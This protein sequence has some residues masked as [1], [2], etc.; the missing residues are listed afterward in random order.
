MPLQQ[1]CTLSYNRAMAATDILTLRLDPA[2]S[3]RLGQLCKATDR[4]K[5]R[6]AAEAIRRFLDENAWQ[7]AAIEAGARAA[8]KGEVVPQHDVEQ[9]VKSWARPRELK[10]PR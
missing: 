7:V 8:D 6:L 2:T 1:A 10:R 4:T 9:W 5:S 3:R